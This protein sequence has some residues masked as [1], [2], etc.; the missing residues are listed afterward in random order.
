MKWF[1]H[2]SDMHRGR[3][4]QT[5]MDEM[6]HAGALS[7]FLIQEMCAEKLEKLDRD[8]TE[9]DCVFVFHERV[10]RQ[11]LRLSVKKLRTFL[12]LSQ[13]L[14]QLRF[15]ING[16]LFQIHMPIL[17]FLLDRDTKKARQKRADDAEKC[18]LDKEEDKD[19]ERELVFTK[20]NTSTELDHSIQLVGCI[21]ELSFDEDCKNLLSG[22]THSS[23]MRWLRLYDDSSYL[24]RELIKMADYLERNPR[25]RPKGAKGMAS[26]IGGWFGRGWDSYRK[27]IAPQQKRE[28]T[29]LELIAE[30]EAV[31]K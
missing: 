2:Y 27:G 13:N 26:F 25:K 21:P 10:L 1:K 31:N 14:G 22:V 17:L 24:K 11:N 19:K 9:S 20:V 7:L 29:F 30:K 3:T 15:E 18:R 6:G 4:I 8:L 12:E 28:K 23:Q 16:N 5:L